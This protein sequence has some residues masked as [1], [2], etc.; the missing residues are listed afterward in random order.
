MKYSAHLYKK[1]LFFER[2]GLKDI[3]QKKK[4]LRN[5]TLLKS[6]IFKQNTPNN[7]SGSRV[8]TDSINKVIAFQH[9]SSCRGIK[10]IRSLAQNGTGGKSEIEMIKRI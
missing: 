7:G 8:V 6:N 10:S 2:V 3:L 1:L 4:Y 5:E 9:P